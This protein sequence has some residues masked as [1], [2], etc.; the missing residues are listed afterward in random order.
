VIRSHWGNGDGTFTLLP[1]LLSNGNPLQGIAGV[2]GVADLNGDGKLDLIVDLALG[3]HNLETVVLLGKGDGT[4][5]PPI[6]V[7]PGYLPPPFL[8]AD[9]NNDGR[10]DIVFFWSTSAVSGIGVELNTTPPGFELSASALSPTSVTAGNS[11]TS[12]L[13]VVPTFGFSS[14]VTLSCSGLPSGAT[15][16]FNPPTIVNSSGSSV[17]TISTTASTVPGTYPVKVLG[18]ASSIANSVAVSLVVQAPPDFVLSPSS[19][20]PT[21]QTISAGQT[22]SFSLGVTP[23]GAFT[24]G[25]SLACAITPVVSAAPTCSLSSSTVNLNGSGT[26][27]VTVSV[28]TTGSSSANLPVPIF[29]FLGR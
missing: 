11:A 5:G 25:V 17:L 15:C 20:S 21:S 10:P 29:N 16:S 8:V 23:S 14:S 7:P 4:F 9:M 3:S 13:T 28:K 26:Q 2:A 24:E 22:A 27:T 12:T 18:S 6:N 19:S 1:P